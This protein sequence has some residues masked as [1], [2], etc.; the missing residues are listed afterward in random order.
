MLAVGLLGIALHDDLALENAAGM[1]I[2]HA[3]EELAR[4]AVRHAVVDDDTGVGVLLS[5]EQE[6]A[7]DHGIAMLAGE[8]DG[9]ILPVEARARCEREVAQQGFCGKR[10]AGM[11][12]MN[13]LGGFDL[14]LHPVKPCAL[15][16]GD[17][18]DGTGE[19]I[20]LAEMGFNQRGRCARRNGDGIAD[21]DGAGGGLGRDRDDLDGGI[22]IAGDRQGHAIG[23]ESGVHLGD[24]LIGGNGRKIVNDVEASRI[25]EAHIEQAIHED[26]ARLGDLG[27]R[28]RG[29][30]APGIRRVMDNALARRIGPV[31]EL[32]QIGPAPLLHAPVRQGMAEGGFSGRF[33]KGEGHA[34]S[35][36]KVRLPL[37]GR[38][39]AR[40]ADGWG[41]RAGSAQKDSSST[42]SAGSK[43]LFVC[44]PHTPPPAAASQRRPPRKGE[45]E[46]KRIMPPLPQTRH[47]PLPQ[48]PA[49]D[50]CRRFSRCGPSTGHGR[51]QA[52]CSRAGAGSE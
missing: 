17:E 32:A 42:N 28:R 23:G 14:H 9:A 5:R 48:A 19:I 12:E 46:L 20:A 26:D 31:D 35:S 3:F 29:E 34:A 2:H 38:P 22:D 21:G 43:S 41:S 11:G 51:N 8:A 18:A 45:V 36:T 37:A 25:R 33:C 13:G 1:I 52:R 7:V 6:G 49:P 10:H 44:S 27:E 16:K 15:A 39:A 30:Q 4:G 47:S 24:G 50:P 40:S